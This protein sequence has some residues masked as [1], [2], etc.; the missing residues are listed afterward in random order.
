MIWLHRHGRSSPLRHRLTP[1]QGQ[2]GVAATW[3]P[4][5]TRSGQTL[6]SRRTQTRHSLEQRQ[7][8]G[9]PKS[10]CR[11]SRP[12]HS[13]HRHRRSH[14]RSVHRLRLRRR[15]SSISLRRRSRSRSH[16]SR[17]SLSQVQGRAMSQ[18]QPTRK[19]P[20][21]PTRRGRRGPRLDQ[22]GLPI[23]TQRQWTH[24]HRR[25]QKAPK[26]KLHGRPRRR[27]PHRRARRRPAP[28]RQARSRR[29]RARSHSSRRSSCP[30]LALPR[31]ARMQGS[32]RRAPEAARR[33]C[34]RQGP[35]V[36]L[37]TAASTWHGPPTRPR[38]R[39][40]RGVPASLRGQLGRRASRRA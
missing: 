20:N 23:P 18:G 25:R 6:L 37:L 8:R 3:V 39:L 11:R 35:I 36:G 13:H 17:S 24:A 28:V 14:R 29:A 30:G 15:P 40:L 34:Q 9:P 7:R 26:A 19:P 27:G 4:L 12:R 16:R 32:P 2:P 22:H 31:R 10:S 21:R 38:H 33:R 1:R 5:L